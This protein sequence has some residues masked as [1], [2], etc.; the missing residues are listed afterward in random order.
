M[1]SDERRGE[2]K[3]WKRKDLE[4]KLLVSFVAILLCVDFVFVAV[5]VRMLVKKKNF[6]NFL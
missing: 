6:S 3:V 1:D 2:G 5:V 4:Q